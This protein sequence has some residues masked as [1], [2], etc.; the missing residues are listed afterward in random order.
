MLSRVV[1]HHS[2]TLVPIYRAKHLAADRNR[3]V[4]QVKHKA[5]AFVYIKDLCGSYLARVRGLTAS[6][7]KKS[8]LVKQHRISVFPLFA[9]DGNGREIL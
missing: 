9:P 6:V 7:W 2:E 8:R 4:C 5:A 1:L 3:S